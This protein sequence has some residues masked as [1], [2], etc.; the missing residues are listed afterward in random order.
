LTAVLGLNPGHDGAVALI[1]DGDLAYS[2]EAEKNSFERHSALTGQ[3]LVEALVE[4]PTFPDV[5]ALGGWYKTIPGLPA[6]IAAGYHGIEPGQRREVRVLGRPTA[7]YTSSHE[8]SH[9]FGGVAMSPFDPHGDLVVLVWEGVLGAFYRWQGPR[10]PI[11]RH[12]VLDQPGGRYAALYAI[13]DPGFSD[14]GTVP[15]SEH[16]GKL[17]ALAGCA[18]D[19]PPAP[20]SVNVVES[21]LKMRLLY[22]FDKA[23]YRFSPLYNRG[24]VDADPEVC[25][26]ARY[27]TQRIFDIYHNAAERLFEPGL[28][29]VIAGG[30]GLNC[31]WNSLWRASP[32]FSEVFVPPVAN[33]AG[34]AI[35]TAVD[36]YVQ[37]GGDCNLKWDVYRGPRFVNDTDPASLTWVTRDLDP[38]ALSA[39]LD[40]GEIVAWVQG[41]CEIGPRAL[42]NRSLLASA[43]DP[44]SHKRLNTMKQRASYRP[45]AP[46]CLEEDLV[47]WFDR[48]HPDPYM[49]Y[50]RKVLDR[51]RIPA[52]T[53]VDGSARAQ[54]ITAATH[55]RLHQLL[56][57]HRAQTGVGVLCNTSLNFSGTG[58]INCGSELIHFCDQVGINHV[59]V[60][61]R[62]YTR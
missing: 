14:R 58:F 60:D 25:R 40:Q 13:A 46:V 32:V 36:A 57:A 48:D 62:W 31:E 55:P 29:M 11:V 33:D 15:Q 50:F 21:L 7:L 56:V 1:V 22:P 47:R 8:R 34:S 30:C 12:E 59:V 51:E 2:L 18:D 53:H 10:E 17:M 42:G 39:A 54:S 6:G 3:V 49:L 41:R 16:A 45:I 52:V 38:V 61:D 23:R 27:L 35:G 26:A 44:R 24:V 43:S 20:D 19:Q 4:A 5:V 28:P 9:L 37:L